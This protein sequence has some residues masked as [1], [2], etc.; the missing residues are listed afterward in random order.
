MNPLFSPGILFGNRRP[1][2]IIKTYFGRQ[3]HLFSQEYG[4]RPADGIDL[5]H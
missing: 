1:D 2:D 4:G 3:G 5:L